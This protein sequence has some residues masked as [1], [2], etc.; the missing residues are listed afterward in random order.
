MAEDEVKEK[1]MAKTDGIT[2]YV[3]D[4]CGAD[5][6]LQQGAAAA[7]DWREV[8]RFDQ[9]GSKASRLLCK[10]CTDEYKQLAAQQD[11]AFQAFM[12]KKGE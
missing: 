5:A 1:D 4:R 7:G 10:S 11:A 6:Y 12:A 2:H 3:C 8:E 9:Y